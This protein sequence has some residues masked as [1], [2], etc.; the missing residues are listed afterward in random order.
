MVDY[1]Y[2]DLF[3]KSHVDKQLKIAADDGSFTATNSD[4]HFEDFELTESLC[5]D[6]E[7]R[8]G[9]C[10]TSM[11]KFQ[12][13]NAFI[14]L[15]G[16]WLTI[17]ETLDVNTD[18]PFQYGRY[19]VFSDVPTADREYR[20]IVA[21][22]AMYDILSADVAAWY[23][24]ILPNKNST[25]TMK[26]F[27]ESF[28]RYFGL[29]EVVPE[30]GLVNDDMIIEKTIDI[31]ASSESKTETEQTSVIG[32]TLSGKDI[33]TAICEINGCFG[34]IGRD[35]K[36]HYI[37]LPQAIEG[38]YPADDLFPSNTLYPRDPKGTRVGNGTY[39][40]IKWKDFR[41]KSITKLQIRQEANDIGR[42]YPEPDIPVKPTDNCYIIQDNFLVYGKSS[43][44]LDV[45]AA[46]IFSKI[47]GI[48]YNPL[49]SCEAMGNLCIEVGDPIRMSTK[50]ALIETYV[51]ER[52]LKG[53]QALRDT[54]KANGTQQYT[55]KVNGVHQSILQL[56]GKSNVLERT[57]EIT[58]L[59][60]KDMGAGL[61]TEIA[62]TAAGIRTDVAKTYETKSDAS[63]E[64]TSIRSSIS[65][66][67]GR[68]SS[69]IERATKAEQ[70]LSGEISSTTTTL[71]SKIEQTESSIIST[72]SA[73]YETKTN[74]NN[75]YTNI[76]SSVQQNA[77]SIMAEVNRASSAEGTLSTRITATENGLTTKVSKGDISSEI[78]QEAG[79]ITIS[80]NRFVLS[81]TNC[82]ISADGKITAKEVDIS[83]KINAT[84]GGKIG[85]FTIGT[86]SLYN[87]KSSITDSSSGVYIGTDGIAVGYGGS[88]SFGANFVVTKD[89]KILIGYDSAIETNGNIKFLTVNHGIQYNEQKR[90]SFDTFQTVFHADVNFDSAKSYIKSNNNNSI[91]LETSR[92]SIVS[93]HAILGKSGEYI[94]FFGNDGATKKNVAKISSTAS[95]TAS[96]V[97]TTL[98]SLLDALKAYNL[99]G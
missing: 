53:I 95:A 74:A 81:S 20:D 55:E 12:I 61:S 71:T 35:G 72:V 10:E 41:T 36:F 21:Y 28:I 96:V 45:I 46:N 64:Y 25:V 44:Q 88:N 91:E 85:G 29:E 33:I 7:L 42:I 15:S 54:Y 31:V 77:D 65:A 98:N 47:I 94:G 9:S 38:L 78:S 30:G 56:K 83:G 17:T 73:T 66:E 40:D 62:V 5:S 48:T 26:Q 97:A 75:E 24:T 79:Q 8:F 11:V 80:A 1:K 49:E 92:T 37:Y 76:K 90:I 27:R 43:E 22:D 89:G 23:N 57:I 6:S 84:A 34:H 99:I 51:L 2:K 58:R 68:I 50:Y 19:K 14:P 69:E 32:E 63:T 93:T 67:A 70:N 16:K 18:V 59:E 52:T 4:I 13:R 60:M 3:L 82:S 86:F 39:I 87:S